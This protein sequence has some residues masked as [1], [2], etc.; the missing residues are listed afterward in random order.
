MTTH[1]IRKVQV[2][3]FGGPEVVNIV[4][5]QIAPPA[6]NEVQ[7]DVAYSGFNGADINMRQG[8]YPQQKG[9]P[10][11]PGY[12]FVGRV[13]A[14]GP[15]ASR[16]KVGDLVG[17]LS[18]YDSEAEKTNCA[19][20]YLVAI[21]EHVDMREACAIFIDWLTSY[22]LTTRAV[23]VQK[24]QRVFIHGMSG[25]VGYG[26]MT[27]CKLAGAE[28]YGTA[29][30]SKHDALRARGAIPFTYKDKKWMDAIK[31]TGGA[32]VVYDPLGFESWDES[33]DILTRNESSTLVGFGGN[34]NIFNEGAKPRSQFPAIIKLLAKNGCLW[35]RRSTTFYYIDRDRATF[36]EDLQTIMNMLSER[37]FEIPIKAEWDL[38]DIRTPHE[39]WNSI[40]GM[41]SCL[42]RVNKDL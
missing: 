3:Q 9:A 21:P 29:S 16:F 40:P 28:V 32:H 36:M 13:S 23:K 10:L 7:V 35:T 42:I 22:C 18:V 41:G 5:A 20:K 19:E 30:E 2:G 34:L 31:A 39:T 27:L 33:Y 25:A 8:T 15:G 6:R 37:K 12:C 14:N 24:G 38:D 17:A 11:T 4:S 1:T 26:L